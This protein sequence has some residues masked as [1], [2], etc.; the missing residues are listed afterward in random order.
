MEVHVVSKADNREHAVVTLDRPE[1]ESHSLA[2]SSVRVQ[3][4]LIALTSNNLSYARGGDFLH[5][6]DT[7]PVPAEL[8]PP[9]ND[10]NSWGIVPA[11][12]FG[13]VTESTTEITLGTLLWGF[14]PTASIPVLLRLQPSE[15]KG[16]WTEISESR[17]RLMTIY[18]AYME[19]GLV[20]LPGFVSGTK[21]KPNLSSL[22]NEDVLKRMS[23]ISLFRPTWQTGYL[24]SR[25]TFTSSPAS[26]PPIHPLGMNLPWTPADADISAAVMISLSASSKTARSFAYHV[27]RRNTAE[28]GPVGFLQVSQTPELLESVAGKLGAK[29]ST[30][31][32]RYDQVGESVEWIV[33][34]RP[35]RI[36]L[37]DFGARGGTLPHLV[38]S[39]MGHSALKEVKTTIIQ[40]GSEQKVSNRKINSPL[41]TITKKLPHEQVYSADDIKENRESMQKIGKI[42]FNTSAVRDSAV[43]KTS[44]QDYYSHVQPVWENWMRVSHEITP[45]IQVTVGRG[46]SGDEGID[47][48]WSR[49]CQGSVDTQEGLVYTM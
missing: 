5:W 37:V 45:D 38:E 32:V 15:V 12:G 4:L 2:E 29:I 14:W 42:Q 23:W 41:N 21:T 25:H 24:L 9:Y 16:H 40:V 18:N 17:Q 8:P 22:V 6:W 46:V 36:V 10:Q 11:W 44:A 26:R 7:Y 48:G 27:F 28:E 35:E 43:E 19:E 49:L 31:A 20:V 39:I 47:K 1:D 3:P 13:V 33:G 30:K 34:L